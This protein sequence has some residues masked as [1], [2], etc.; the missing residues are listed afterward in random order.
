MVE[1]GQRRRGPPK[2]TPGGYAL[3]VHNAVGEK[4]SGRNAAPGLDASKQ[5]ASCETSPHSVASALTVPP[6]TGGNEK[7]RAG[8]GTTPGAPELEAH[9][10][11][12]ALRASAA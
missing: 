7:P 3:G 8:L 12:T 10:R 1:L 9:I 2:G 11:Q 4:P 5:Y 6:L